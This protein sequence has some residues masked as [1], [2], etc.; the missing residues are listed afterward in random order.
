MRYLHTLDPDEFRDM[1]AFD[2]MRMRI[3]ADR[4]ETKQDKKENNQKPLYNVGI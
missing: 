3:E 1:G 2:R 4:Y